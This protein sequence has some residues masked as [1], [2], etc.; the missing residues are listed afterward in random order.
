M[1]VYPGNNCAP[2][3]ISVDDSCGCTLTRAS[4]Q[5][6]TPELFE[7][8]GFKEVGMDRVIGQM[9]E[10]RM[11]GVA[12][13]SLTDLFLSRT[14]PLKTQSLFQS[15]QRSVIAPFVMVPQRSV[16]NANWFNL[17]DGEADP[18]AGSAASRPAHGI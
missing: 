4:I 7:E 15:G 6:F 1:A 10:A 9:K 12:E 16:V 17:V 13:R 3:L 8:Q 5:A 11:A 14:V 18:N 2:R